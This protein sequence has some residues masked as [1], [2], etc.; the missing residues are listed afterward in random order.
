MSLLVNLNGS[1]VVSSAVC[2]FISSTLS[3]FSFSSSSFFSLQHRISCSLT[4]LL[5]HL[6][7]S[8]HPIS[9]LKLQYTIPTSFLASVHPSTSLPSARCFSTSPSSSAFSVC[10]ALS[11]PQNHPVSQPSPKGKIWPLPPT[12]F[13]LPS[14]RS[15]LAWARRQPQSVTFTALRTTKT[16]KTMK[17]MMTGL[18]SHFLP[19]PP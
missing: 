13:A 4:T 3:S 16:T 19:H 7:L 18:S 9:S 8:L 2:L 10:C 15:S 11:T 1:C 17:T 12:V 14:V 5:F 6:P